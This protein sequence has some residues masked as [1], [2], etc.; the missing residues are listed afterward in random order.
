MN[1]CPL[2]PPNVAFYDVP[3]IIVNIQSA[4]GTPAYLKLSVSLELDIAGRK[5]RHGRR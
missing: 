2:T 4:D 5:G 3:D 1:S